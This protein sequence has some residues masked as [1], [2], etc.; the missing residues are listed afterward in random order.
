MRLTRMVAMMAGHLGVTVAHAEPVAQFF[1][2][3]NTPAGYPCVLTMS[4]ARGDRVAFQ[5][6]DYQDVWSINIF[7]SGVPERL[8]PYFDENG[9]RDSDAFEGTFRELTFGTQNLRVNDAELWEV[10]RDAL[11]D[12][13][14]AMFSIKEA[15]NVT[16]ALEA[17]EADGFQ[18][19][20]LVSLTGT[21]EAFSAFREC[22]YPAMG[23]AIDERVETD[24][25]AEYRMIFERSFELWVRHTTRAGLCRYSG[26]S[27][28]E[29][30][31]VIGRAAAAF[32]PGVL[33]VQRR[34]E[35][36]ERLRGQLPF[37]RLS[38]STD[39]MRSCYMA[40]DL[41]EM[42]LIPVEQAIKSAEELN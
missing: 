8:R 4:T 29:V 40:N 30:D 26:V 7:I 16:S 17:M 27:E 19:G 14:S 20:P 11:D 18:I 31:R 9:L 5:L 35:Y 3:A 38:G 25:R 22:V 21:S 24:F 39:A 32:Y 2:E 34:G 15:H 42:A 41:A 1:S 33:N 36:T 6:S 10:E 13:S 28:E 23:L 12:D 37:F